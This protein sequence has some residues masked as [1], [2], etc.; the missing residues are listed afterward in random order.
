MVIS[1]EMER[2]LKVLFYKIYTTPRRYSSNV[3]LIFAVKQLLDLDDDGFRRMCEELDEKSLRES[4]PEVMRKSLDT[5]EADLADNRTDGNGDPLA[6]LPVLGDRTPGA[7]TSKDKLDLALLYID[8]G[9]IPRAAD[10]LKSVVETDRANVDAWRYLADAHLIASNLANA[11]TTLREAWAVPEIPAA[12]RDGFEERLAALR[13]K[14]A[15]EHYVREVFV[16]PYLDRADTLLADGRC[17]DAAVLY[18]HA[19]RVMPGNYELLLRAGAAWFRLGDASRAERC[20]EQSL[21]IME[22]PILVSNF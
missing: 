14:F 3:R 6:E 15:D 21:V 8:C 20:F 22:M 4:I 5:L 1:S 11:E 10:L 19:A 16:Q 12:D 13:L 18:E 17:G 2:L 7:L 9:A